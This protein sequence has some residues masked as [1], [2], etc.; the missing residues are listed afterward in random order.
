MIYEH[1]AVCMYV[2]LNEM[3]TRTIRHGPDPI[4]RE[5]NKTQATGFGELMPTT[6]NAITHNQSF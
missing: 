5:D 2:H 6:M 3:C 1:K 4:T